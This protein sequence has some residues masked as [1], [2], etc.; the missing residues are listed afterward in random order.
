MDV[1]DSIVLERT[2]LTK[3]QLDIVKLEHKDWY[4]TADEAKNYGIIDEII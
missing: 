4:M 3:E 2:N 1:Y